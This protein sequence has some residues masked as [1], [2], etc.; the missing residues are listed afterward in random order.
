M[1]GLASEQKDKKF[2][3]YR[4]IFQEK[5]IFLNVYCRSVKEEHD[6]RGPEGPY[7]FVDRSVPVV[8]IKRWDGKTFV[9]QLGFIA[10][11]KPGLS[12]LSSWVDKALKENGPV[13]PPKALRPLLKSWTK[14]TEHLAKNR[15]S[16]AIPELL[17]ITK[18]AANKKKFPD[19]P[20][21]VAALATAKLEELTQIA[22][23]GVSAADDIADP[24]EKRKALNRIQRDYGRI[25][26]IKQLVKEKLKT[27]P[28]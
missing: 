21:E 11:Q 7:Q 15:P 16:S 24:K 13:V 26:A 5:F 23:R 22:R 9:Q 8:V 12:R 14:A 10:G 2:K 1:R 20:P 3:K 19:G 4:K 18:G 17:K 6:P 25:A 28:K 27:I